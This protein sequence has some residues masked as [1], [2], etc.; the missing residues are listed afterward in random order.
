MA[1]GLGCLFKRPEPRATFTLMVRAMLADVA[2]KNSWGLAEYAGL[3]TPQAF[4]H[5]LNGAKWSADE[6]RDQIRGY[7]LAGL[8]DPGG[9]LVLDDTQAI[10]KGSK[11]VG[12]GAC[13]NFR[14]TVL[15]GSTIG[16]RRGYGRGRRF[17]GS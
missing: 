2:K 14:V 12:V 1:D 5:L 4:E 8:A 10:K 15:S 9:A 7:V 17:P 6:L 11:S 16:H 3:A 13:Q